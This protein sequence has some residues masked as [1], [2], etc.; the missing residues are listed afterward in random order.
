MSEHHEETQEIE[1]DHFRWERPHFYF[2]GEKYI[3]QIYYGQEN[4]TQ[5]SNCVVITLD[6]SM[7][8]SLDWKSARQKALELPS[9]IK[10]LWNMKMGLFS[11]LTF[12]LTKE[13]QFQS[14]IIALKHFRETLWKEFKERSLGVILYEGRLDFK[15]GFLWDTDQE[16]DF[17]GW[18]KLHSVTGEIS[19]DHMRLYCRDACSEYL[20]LLQDGLS[21]AVPAFLLFDAQSI[22]DPLTFA[23]MIASDRWNRF[24]LAIKRP[25]FKTQHLTWQ[26]TTIQASHD[27]KPITTGVCIP[28]SDTIHSINFQGLNEALTLLIQ[29][30]IPFRLMSESYLT[31]EW[32]GIDHLIYT[33]VGTSVQGKRKLQGFCAAGGVPVYVGNKGLNISDEISLEQFARV[34]N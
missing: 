31:A 29:K 24:H 5:E 26:G 22:Q 21:D 1:K 23:Q 17:G 6:G 8:S 15:R 25:P 19:Q 9:N 12:P 34:A 4:V 32:E 20:Q 33:A 13:M 30:N 2:Q 10:I 7:T 14:F 16:A 11:Y 18:Q 3:P 27:P 28:S